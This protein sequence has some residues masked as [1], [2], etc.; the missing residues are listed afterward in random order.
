MRVVLADYPGVKETYVFGVLSKSDREDFTSGEYKQLRE[1]K[2][3]I[4]NIIHTR[5]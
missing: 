3:Q 2:R 1:L 4:D 5:L